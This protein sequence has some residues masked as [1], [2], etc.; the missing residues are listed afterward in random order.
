MSKSSWTT[1]KFCPYSAFMRLFEI[2]AKDDFLNITS[3]Y[4]YKEMIF[5]SLVG[6]FTDHFLS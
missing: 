2:A 3:V 4:I 5:S 1:A 6:F